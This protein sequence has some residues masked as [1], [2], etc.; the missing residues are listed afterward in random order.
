M[1]TKCRVSSGEGRGTGVRCQVSGVRPQVSRI[2]KQGWAGLLGVLGAA[3]LL[4]SGCAGPRALRGGQ[5]TMARTPQGGWEQTLAQGEN[6]A[7][8]TRQEQ[9]S[10][11][12]RTYVLPAGSRFQI[13]E[14]RVSGGGEEIRNPK[15]EARKKGRRLNCYFLEIGAPA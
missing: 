11:R 10:L 12:V 9:D 2:T 15:A 1:Q 4:V 14:G 3:A 6:P 13:Q 8:A 7:Q 5:A